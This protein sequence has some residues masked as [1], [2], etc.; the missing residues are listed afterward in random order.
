MTSVPDARLAA[1]RVILAARARD[2]ADER[3]RAA[4][5]QFGA[6]L[7]RLARPFDTDA[8]PTHVTS[9]AIIVGPAG[10]VLHRHKRLGLWLQ[11]GGHLDAGEDLARAGLREAAEETGLV[12]THPRDGPSAVHVDVHE[13]GRGHVHLDVRWLVLGSG[14]PHPPPGESPD[15]R[16]FD[17]ESAIVTADPG[18][19][20]ALRQLRPHLG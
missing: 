1:V 8:D 17:W 3:E 10:V 15:V 13:G 5:E 16:W 9:S 4:V 14:D 12:V 19:A 6:A 18:L 11:P 2:P 7:D 20:G